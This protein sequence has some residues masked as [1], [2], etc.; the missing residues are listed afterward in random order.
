MKFLVN[1]HVPRRIVRRLVELGHDATHTMDLPRGNRTSDS[2]I[3]SLCNSEERVLITKDG[4]F[5]HS[6]SS[7]NHIN[8]C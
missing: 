2:F 6:Y 8:C 4:D 1:A 7:V 5:V 3:N